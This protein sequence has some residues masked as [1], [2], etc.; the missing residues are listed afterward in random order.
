MRLYYYRSFHPNFGDEL[1][2]WLWPQ[3]V[4]N[5]GDETAGDDETLL[6][7]IGTILNELIPQ[8]PRKLVFSSGIGY[9]T[10]PVLDDR[11]EIACVRGPRTAKALGLPAELAITD[12]AALLRAV[13]LPSSPSKTGYVAFV[14]H[15]V[16]ALRADWRAITAE[17]GLV[18]VDPR[19]SVERVLSRLRGAR[20]VVTEAMHGAI[21]ADALRV[22]WIPVVCY[23]HINAFKWQDWC[24]SLAVPYAPEV[25]P[26]VYE[27]LMRRPREILRHLRGVA[28]VRYW[29]PFPHQPADVVLSGRRERDAA[30][31]A[32]SRFARG[33][34]Y[35][36][37]DADIERA[38]ARLLE[39]V[40]MIRAATAAR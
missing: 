23:G 31:D 5:V 4:P 10:L 12:G 11:W 18:Y 13:P 27:P 19:D 21:C 8:A 39:R 38:T 9:G 32:L 6:V 25:V 33:T 14:P 22:P 17:A 40:D 26:S 15:H 2:P 28:R 30:V 1:N 24:G 37:T 35:L 16:S 36:S 20:L 7:G 29:E 3:L 34:S